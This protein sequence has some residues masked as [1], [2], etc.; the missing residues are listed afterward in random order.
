MFQGLPAESFLSPKP[1]VR[2][3]EVPRSS[4]SERLSEPTLPRPISSD[5]HP[6]E[7]AFPTEEIPPWLQKRKP[8]KDDRH[9]QD[10]SPLGL[11]PWLKKKDI[12]LRELEGPQ[13]PS[14]TA[15][16]QEKYKKEQATIHHERHSSS[17]HSVPRDRSEDSR[18]SKSRPERR[19]SADRSESQRRSSSHH[20]DA[21]RRPSTEHTESHRK[22]STEHDE[23]LGK[24]SIDRTEPPRRSPSDS[25]TRPDVK[26]PPEAR[27]P[28]QPPD[29]A[30]SN[31]AV[32]SGDKVADKVG[33]DG[34]AAAPF[35]P[36]GYIFEKADASVAPRETQPLD[37]SASRYV[38]HD[39]G[40]PQP[41]QVLGEPIRHYQP[42][43]TST[44]EKVQDQ[45]KHPA[46]RPEEN[47]PMRRSSS[48]SREGNNVDAPQTSRETA[49]HTKEHQQENPKIRSRSG[50]TDSVEKETSSQQEN[51]K[52]RSRWDCTESVEKKTSS[53]QDK[54]HD[55]IQAVEHYLQE[56]PK[57][58][59]RW[60]CTESV[61]KKTPS[62]QDESH[63]SIHAV[64]HQ[65]RSGSADSV[66]K[67]TS[68]QQENPKIR[69]RWDC[70]ESV[71]KKTSSEQ[72]KS[73]AS[74][75]AVQQCVQENQKNRSRWDCTEV[76]EKRTSS[77]QDKSHN[78]KPTI[79]YHQ[80]EKPKIRSRS[81]STDSGEKT[82]SE[83]DK[84]RNSV[85]VV[86]YQP[87][88]NSKSRSRSSSTDS[89]EKK[90]PCEQD[91]SHVSIPTVRYHQKEKPKIRSRSGST[92][93]GEKKSSSEQDKSWEKP[94]IRSRSGSTDSGEKKSSSE[95][96]KSWEK[97]K[98]RS[99]SGSTDSGEKKSSSEKDKSRNSVPVV[100]YQQKENSKSRSRSSSTD[101]IEKKTPSEQDKSHVSIPVVDLTDE[102]ENYQ[103]LAL[104]AK[105]T[106]SASSTEQ[107]KT[108]ITNRGDP[109][110]SDGKDQKAL[111]HTSCTQSVRPVKRRRFSLS[112][113]RRNSIDS[114]DEDISEH[115]GHAQT[116]T[117]TNKNDFLKD[118]RNVIVIDD[119]DSD[120]T[121][122]APEY[123]TLT[124]QDVNTAEI[125]ASVTGPSTA[126]K[127]SAQ[128]MPSKGIVNHESHE[129]E[130]EESV[131]FE[132]EPATP[133][134]SDFPSSVSAPYPHPNISDRFADQAD[135]RTA[136]RR[137][138][139]KQILKKK[140]DLSSILAARRA[141]I[142]TT[143]ELP[144]E[145]TLVQPESSASPSALTDTPEGPSTV[146]E[147]PT[148]VNE[149]HASSQ[150]VTENPEHPPAVIES[151]ESPPAMT[152]S[153]ESPPAVS[154]SP[155]SP[156]LVTESPESPS[157]VIESPESPPLVTES[158]QRPPVVSENPDLSDQLS[159]KSTNLPSLQNA[160]QIETSD[161]VRPGTPT[162]KNNRDVPEKTAE[163]RSNVV[164]PP[165]SDSD[166]D[167][168]GPLVIASETDQ[169]ETE[170]HPGTTEEHPGTTNIT[171]RSAAETS[172]EPEPATVVPENNEVRRHSP[173]DITLESLNSATPRTLSQ[174]EEEGRL[175]HPDATVTTSEATQPVQSTTGGD[176]AVTT[177]TTSEAKEA[178]QSNPSI[179]K[180]SNP[181]T[182]TTQ[183]A[184]P[185]PEI[186]KTKSP[187]KVK[188]K[189][190]IQAGQKQAVKR[191][192]PG[193]S[194]AAGGN[195]GGPGQSAQGQ[196][197][198]SSAV[199]KR[200]IIKTGHKKA[201]QLPG[202]EGIEDLLPE[203]EQPTVETKE[204]ISITVPNEGS[205]EPDKVEPEQIVLK[206]TEPSRRV[207]LKTK[208]KSPK[209]T[210]KT[211]KRDIKQARAA[212]EAL[213][214]SVK[215]S[216]EATSE[217]VKGLRDS[218]TNLDQE[219][220][221]KPRRRPSTESREQQG[222]S[223]S[224]EEGQATET[225]ESEHWSDE[226]DNQRERRLQYNKPSWDKHQR[227]G[228][229]R[230]ETE[231]GGHHW[232]RDQRDAGYRDGDYRQERYKKG[233]YWKGGYEDEGTREWVSHE[234]KR[235]P[236]DSKRGGRYSYKP[237]DF[238]P[239]PDH[240]RE[241]YHTEETAD[242]VG[243][244][245]LLESVKQYDR[246]SFDERSQGSSSSHTKRES[247]GTRP[248]SPAPSTQSHHSEGG[249]G[250][251]GSP[252]R[253]EARAGSYT[254]QQSH[255]SRSRSPLQ[256]R[257]RSRSPHEQRTNSREGSSRYREDYSDQKSY[258][259][260]F[261]KV[262][263]ESKEELSSS[264]YLRDS[265]HGSDSTYRRQEYR[266]SGHRST[267]TDRGYHDTNR[268]SSYN[269][270]YTEYTY[271]KPGQ[272]GDTYQQGTTQHSIPRLETSRQ[273]SA[274]T[275]QSNP[276]HH[277]DSDWRQSWE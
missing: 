265:Y 259:H 42:Q 201:V 53:E 206:V 152:E 17:S 66:E 220:N 146:T 179:V 131:Q 79:E 45:D 203:R 24:S 167:F 209:K 165:D 154:E 74:I 221:K 7:H 193:G 110:A 87:K 178:V 272:S 51:P 253:R 140:S 258:M 192:L 275:Y 162:F 40:T 11:P 210:K 196:A 99:R 56:N 29:A 158:P 174:R 199:K 19:S 28:S 129:R 52:I 240:T 251:E 137:E 250:D 47:V 127:T 12:D 156:P 9:Q 189:K 135:A 49:E 215:A 138:L 237:R 101:S 2:P 108:V 224:Q 236:F 62:E 157:L 115:T 212:A 111:R 106:Q 226:S 16:T 256:C 43:Q 21:H 254:S 26:D 61:E 234:W 85:P 82:Y 57:I 123:E 260:R 218:G 166:L 65:S 149:S 153:P 145:P 264:S 77:E 122:E 37:V 225:S 44:E 67:E 27:R 86:K 134:L 1:K 228:H 246:P 243:G 72:D 130:P 4:P 50:S 103:S 248:R 183:N 263:Q 257:S 173:V 274:K 76:V 271:P 80:Q 58:R 60:D 125:R 244:S 15:S 94:K 83:Q 136:A 5:E 117:T 171:D 163:K 139:L 105:K 266:D 175:E 177:T 205:T 187:N 169:D 216:M 35:V 143:S 200:K 161:Y 75:Q 276:Y 38:F 142:D 73:Q 100:E 126:N 23:S 168:P 273:G 46:D 262:K 202:H 55:S 71:E 267:Y 229:P 147:G 151:P 91:K 70:T 69:S 211:K 222:G 41:I 181:D 95:Q 230:R 208:P 252:W 160:T 185:K 90:T 249:G 30:S 89:I 92:D 238:P 214:N 128:S 3:A 10:N 25:A 232:E 219:E 8:P 176:P 107:M 64:E 141:S 261:G 14:E 191:P 81:S 119:D 33:T 186:V 88:E 172:Q 270:T 190:L 198:N 32:T 121:E 223:A 36:D 164:R 241:R 159:N 104:D 68:S 182:E 84:S 217:N 170:E 245:S 48:D 188:K 150:A 98:I 97:P 22:P 204:V 233:G 227:W 195:K 34:N 13:Y 132:T 239:R 269:T 118:D 231:W 155:E 242:T 144:E 6:L 197:Q 277:K 255:R 96:D 124:L 59:S 148:A 39:S 184:A 112:T 194:A 207:E 93:S 20:V 116:S 113:K 268:H 63:N 109:K 180:P 133:T 114:K 213:I 102:P 18:K 235:Q 54:S 247:S 120:S 31:M 78:S